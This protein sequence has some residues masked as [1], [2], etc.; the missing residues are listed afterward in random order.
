MNYYDCDRAIVIA[1]QRFTSQAELEAEKLDVE[2]WD[3][4][5]LLDL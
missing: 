2:L 1:N 4:D 5:I 3:K